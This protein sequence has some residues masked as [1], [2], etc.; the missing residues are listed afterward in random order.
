MKFEMF[1]IEMAMKLDACKSTWSEAPSSTCCALQQISFDTSSGLTDESLMN[2]TA[3]NASIDTTINTTNSDIVEPISKLR[4]VTGN[5][6][7][8][9]ITSDS[10][11][12]IIF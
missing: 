4:K 9:S 10:Y 5:R 2:K 1:K 8:I 12:K 6:N 11:F 3:K 7:L